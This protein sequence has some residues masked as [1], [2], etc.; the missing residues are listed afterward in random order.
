MKLH[1]TVLSVLL[2]I[3]LFVMFPFFWFRRSN[4][5]SVWPEEPSLVFMDYWCKILKS[6]SPFSVGSLV[7][8][9]PGLGAHDEQRSLMVL[10]NDDD[11]ILIPLGSV[12]CI[13]CVNAMYFII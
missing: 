9:S 3:F 10:I 1:L 12:K 6:W 2:Y 13:I 5:G 11:E 8:L 4:F 7:S